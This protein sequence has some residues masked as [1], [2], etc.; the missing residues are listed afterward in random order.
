MEYVS[1][2]YEPIRLRSYS[3]ETK[4]KRITE[5]KKAKCIIVNV[6]FF[7]IIDKMIDNL[8]E[9]EK[10]FFKYGFIKMYN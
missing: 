1:R 3:G 8:F 2:V 6:F 7:I 10:T 9:F 4:F 5:R